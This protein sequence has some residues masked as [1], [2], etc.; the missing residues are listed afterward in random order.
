MTV[1]IKDETSTG[2]IVNEFHLQFRDNETTIR[3]I[4]SNRVT[5]EVQ[6]YN[7]KVP[8]YFQGLVETSDAEKTANGFRLKHR[9]EIDIEKQIYVALNAFQKNGYFIL[10]DDIQAESLEQRVSLTE[11]T[12]ISFLK[13]TPLV[14]G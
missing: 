9:K 4:I 2:K 11:N 10:V 12:Q 3:E 13:L 14:G 6:T 7:E 1:S 8:E 5:K